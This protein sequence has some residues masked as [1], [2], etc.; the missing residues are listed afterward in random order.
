MFNFFPSSVA[1]EIPLSL[2]SPTLPN[3]PIYWYGIL[4][5]TGALV[6]A[7]LASLEAKRRGMDPDHVWNA[8]LLALILGV[9]GARA[10]HVVSVL[11]QG[12]PLGYLND[13][14]TMINPRTGGL[15]IYGA[16]AGGML[17][18]YLYVIYWNRQVAREGSN[19][20]RIS[21]WILVDCA[22]PG[23]TIGQAIGRWGNYFNQ[24]LYGWPTDLPW[25][26]LIDAAHRLPLFGDLTQ[27]PVATTRFHPTF[28]YE[29]LAMFAVTGLLLFIAR[30]YSK[31]LLRGDM[32][33]LYGVFYPVVRFFTEMQRP[34]AWKISGVP[35]AQIIAVAAAV[36]SLVWF[37]YRHTGPAPATRPTAQ[38]A[39]ARRR[40]RSA[41][42]VRAR[43]AQMGEGST[44][45]AK[46]TAPTSSEST[47]ESKPEK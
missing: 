12:D 5:V 15:G 16:V 4:I 28:L 6:G 46:S 25:G 41:D 40:T 27:Y 29:S 37:A 22:V 23:L 43:R 31:S 7:W 36:I 19:L 9:V 3:I 2:I 38:A 33:L 39:T 24:E 44:P 10:Y 18:L 13:P 17:G 30:R 11:A 35:T 8:L 1:F 20:A 14:L 26:I 21:F 47:G 42:Q 45:P 32:F 34:D